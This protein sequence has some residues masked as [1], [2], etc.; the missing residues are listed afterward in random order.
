MT[1]EEAATLAQLLERQKNDEDL[2]FEDGVEL[3]RLINR[4]KVEEKRELN[5]RKN[6]KAVYDSLI[7]GEGI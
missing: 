7:S 3:Q 5:I 1:T 4:K 2:P 6:D